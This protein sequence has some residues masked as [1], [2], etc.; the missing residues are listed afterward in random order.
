MDV[1][2]LIFG[3]IL[4]VAPFVLLIWW[5]VRFQ[6]RM[7]TRAFDNL[8]QIFTENNV[9]LRSAVP[10]NK[11]VLL[12]LSGEKN[13]HNIHVYSEY[14]G[15]GKNRTLITKTE[16]LG[17]NSPAEFTL[18][19]E[20]LF[21]KIGEALGMKDVKTGDDEFDK[22]YRL[23]SSHPDAAKFFTDRIRNE[24]VAKHKL[25]NGTTTFK[26]NKLTLVTY[27][28]PGNKY[29]LKHYKNT[30]ELGLLFIE[31]KV[32]SMGGHSPVSV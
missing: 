21:T 13:G 24:F 1:I 22:L 5:A 8:L 27:A 19:R 6:K 18:Y 10:Q 32:S 25:F 7:M 12:R 29:G 3:L 16:L 28:S 2:K 20:N 14:V 9:T 31:K 17:I 15:S 30:F 26:N 4:I 11:A 23:K